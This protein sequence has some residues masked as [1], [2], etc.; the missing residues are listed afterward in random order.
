MFERYTRAD[1]EQVSVKCRAYPFECS[2]MYTLEVWVIESHNASIEHI[3]AA[4]L[5][6]A[7]ARNEQAQLKHEQAS[8]ERN[9]EIWRAIGDAL[10][11]PALKCTTTQYG[12]ASTTRCD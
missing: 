12:G 4:Q 5:G 10:S 11:P 9:A 8:A 3:Y 7:M 6:T 2:K 1:F